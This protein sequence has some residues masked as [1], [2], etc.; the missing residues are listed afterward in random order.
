MDRKG[1][2]AKSFLILYQAFAPFHV[3]S[4][5]KGLLWLGQ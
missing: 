1:A 3:S 5:Q 2:E 4:S